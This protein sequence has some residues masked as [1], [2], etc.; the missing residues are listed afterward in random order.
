MNLENY[1][2][3]DAI[4]GKAKDFA[5]EHKCTYREALIAVCQADPPL[6]AAYDRESRGVDVTVEFS[7]DETRITYSDS[8]SVTS[9]LEA[10]DEIDELARDYMRESG[11]ADYS[12]ALFAVL[13]N[14]DHE[15]LAACYAYGQA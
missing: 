14:P 6:A 7:G 2:P 10:G 3:S 12:Q 9:S 4:D 11:V 5:M 13:A 8:G 1:S 15:D